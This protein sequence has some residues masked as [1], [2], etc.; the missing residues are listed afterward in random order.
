[1]I[2]ECPE[3]GK[4]FDVLWPQLWQYKR[5]TK[6]ICSWSCLRKFDE[7]VANKILM[8]TKKD[9]TPA[10]KPGPKK[11]ETPEQVPVVKVTGPIQIETPEA[12]KVEVVETPEK[13]IGGL[14]PPPDEILTFCRVTALDTPI[15][16][17]HYDKRHGY[18]DWDWD[19]N[20]M[21]LN[22]EEWKEFRKWF[23]IVLKQLGVKL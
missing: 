15:G 16:E 12:G 3:C 19:N 18:L 14:C 6:F 2:N 23:P 7:R 22:M 20:T 8:R 11:I 4:V 10:K 5:G 9:G 17:F 21:S 1:M 13:K